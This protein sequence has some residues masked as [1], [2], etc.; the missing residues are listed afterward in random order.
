MGLRS[1]FLLLSTSFVLAS[2]CSFFAEER[3]V[4]AP[5]D[6]D[7]T[8]I[9]DTTYRDLG[10]VA[11]GDEVRTSF[12]LTN[13]GQSNIRISLAKAD[14]GCVSLQYDTTNI[15]PSEQTI[16]SVAFDTR[17]FE[18]GRHYQVI[19]VETDKEQVIKLCISAKVEIP[20]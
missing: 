3:K 12:S 4:I 19:S 18:R 17:G 7:D 8:L 13:V 9:A 20:K 16:V 1:A 6:L 10:T 2:A 15:A 14:C 11:Q 5:P